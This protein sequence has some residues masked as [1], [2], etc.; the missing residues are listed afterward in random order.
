MRATASGSRALAPRP[1]TVSVGKATKR[2]ARRR[3]AAASISAALGA[4]P[5]AASL[6]SQGGFDSGRRKGLTTGDTEDRGKAQKTERAREKF[7]ALWVLRK[8]I[9]K[10]S[11]CKHQPQR[12]RAGAPAPHLFFFFYF[13]SSFFS[14][15]FLSSSSTCRLLVTEK[16]LGT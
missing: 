16:T 4:G 15:F 2:P 7:L 3:R 12:Q 14:S 9:R 1:Y 6:L 13:L 8:N 5:I 10:I 11:R